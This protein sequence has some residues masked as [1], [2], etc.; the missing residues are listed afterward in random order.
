M[1]A[2]V[3]IYKARKQERRFEVEDCLSGGGGFEERTHRLP[4]FSLGRALATE[5]LSRK[6]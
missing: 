5:I 1:R 3:G 6:Q 2:N 4:M